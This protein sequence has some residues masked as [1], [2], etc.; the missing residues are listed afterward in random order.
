MRVDHSAQGEV[1]EVFKQLGEEIIEE[2]LTDWIARVQPDGLVS[3]EQLKSFQS[4]RDDSDSSDDEDEIRYHNSDKLVSRSSC[5]C[6]PPSPP[7]HFNFT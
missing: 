5:I 4:E 3:L 1:R 6:I 7:T 2:E